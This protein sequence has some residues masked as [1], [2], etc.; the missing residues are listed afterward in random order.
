MRIAH[1]ITRMIIGGAQEN[2]LHNC[3]D[4]VHLHGDEVLLVTGPAVGPE[5]DLLSE[6]VRKDSSDI[7]DSANDSKGRAGRFELDSLPIELIDSL[8]RAIHPLHDWNAT[9]DLRRTLLDFDP[10]VVHTHSAKGGLLG[11]HVGWGLK[12]AST[13]KRPVVV[14]TVHGAPFHEYQSKLA[15]DFFVRCERWAASRCH[16]LISVADAMTDLMVE[17]GVAPRE[18][19]VT[20]HSGMNVDPFVHAVDHREAVRQR[21][22][23]RDEHV[24]VGK[25]ARLFHLKGHAD[26]VPAAKLVA[27]RH[28]NVRFL[29]VGDGI[30]RG[31][32]EQ[33]IESLGLKEH[34]IFTGLV[35]PS[36]VPAMIGAMDILVHASYREGLA[37]A[38]PQA[39]IAGR[40]AISY[41]IDG[42]REVVIDDQT[43]YLVGAGQVAD[44]ADRMIRLVGDGELRLRMGEEGRTRFTDLFRHETMTQRI[45][46]LYA[47]LISAR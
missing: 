12:R 16:K 37:R 14:H 10:D 27:D 36:E 6:R 11:R 42:A 47:D 29:L 35:P 44:L 24:V 2:T 26:L 8:R 40:P 25:I 18:K 32:L 21:Y 22:G 38:L 43:G 19:F 20:I 31:E 46:E 15:H 41:D 4:L 7:G 34:F 9:R 17:A 3:Q 23:L 13:G 39:L 28:P 1:V 45:R 30:L 5:G 33:Q